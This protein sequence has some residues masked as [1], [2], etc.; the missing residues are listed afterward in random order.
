MH[1]R[2]AT[3]EIS[4][5]E[6]RQSSSN[7]CNLFSWSSA[8][9]MALLLPDGVICPTRVARGCAERCQ[10]S[11]EELSDIYQLQVKRWLSRR[12][13]C[14]RM[15][16]QSRKMPMRWSETPPKRIGSESERSPW[17]ANRGCANG[18]KIVAHEHFGRAGLVSSKPGERT[19][20]VVGA[21]SG[22]ARF[23]AGPVPSRGHRREW[24]PRADP[25]L[26]GAGQFRASVK[27]AEQDL[28]TEARL[29]VGDR[30]S[31]GHEFSVQMGAMDSDWSF[32]GL[33]LAVLTGEAVDMLRKALEE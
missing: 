16:G 29:L 1:S 33:G 7:S 20:V 13:T 27:V 31:K 30:D 32:E 5:P 15:V 18:A 8:Q 22:R 21:Q 9:V 6:H 25:Q 17:N 14:R 23:R 11:R 10:S 24:Q 2:L 19:V 26:A 12:G 28:F 3:P 4:D